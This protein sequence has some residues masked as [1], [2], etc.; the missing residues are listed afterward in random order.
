MQLKTS[1]QQ[2]FR[3]SFRQRCE[4]GLRLRGQAT[5]L[6]S[7]WIPDAV[8][9]NCRCIHGYCVCGCWLRGAPGKPVQWL[10]R[11]R[12]QNVDSCWIPLLD[13]LMLLLETNVYVSVVLFRGNFL[14]LFIGENLSRLQRNLRLQVLVFL[15]RKEPLHSLRAV[16]SRPET[17]QVQNV[18]PFRVV[19]VFVQKLSALWQK[20][21]VTRINILANGFCGTLIPSDIYLKQEADLNLTQIWRVEWDLC[22][23]CFS[24]VV[25]F[26]D[27]DDIVTVISFLSGPTTFRW[28]QSRHAVISTF[29]HLCSPS[30]AVVLLI[31]FSFP[32]VITKKWNVILPFA[33]LGGVWVSHHRDISSDFHVFWA[34]LEKLWWRVRKSAVRI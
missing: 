9:V 27:T 6:F 8:L 15:N 2:V 17:D 22:R 4:L 7:A 5:P 13:D 3:T 18:K 29:R 23:L 26:C 12:T 1:L 11:K 19:T 24:C 31:S 10:G 33:I 25:F 14:L 28:T 21:K 34:E 20:F 30:E 32:F 16:K